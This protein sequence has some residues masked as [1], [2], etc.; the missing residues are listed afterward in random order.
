MPRRPRNYLPGFPHHVVQRGNNRETCFIASENDQFHLDLWKALSRRHGVAVHADRLMTNH[1][2][3][4]VTPESKASISSTLKVAASRYAQY[5]NKKYHRTG[6]LWE[7]RHRS[8]LVQSERYL[9]TCTRYI[10]LNPVVRI[11]SSGRKSI[12]GRATG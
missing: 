3:F 1:I 9:L 5:I 2:H 4:L 8:S 12:E 10:E 11:W 6:T 7:G